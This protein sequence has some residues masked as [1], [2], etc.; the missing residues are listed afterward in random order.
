MSEYKGFRFTVEK[1]Q[2]GHNIGRGGMVFVDYFYIM[3]G[4]KRVGYCE[5]E[6]YAKKICKMLN[7][8]A[9]SNRKKKNQTGLDT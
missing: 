7:D 5:S 4:P 1:K 2:Q 8:E 6:Y 3:K 9:D